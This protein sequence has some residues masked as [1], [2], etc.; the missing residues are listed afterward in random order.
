MT[1][2]PEFTASPI[3]FAILGAGR[4]GLEHGR[5]LVGL[6]EAQVV[7]VADPIEEAAQRVARL[8]RAGRTYS[9]PLDA[10]HDPEVQAVIIVTPT[11]THA[12]LIEAAANAGKAIFCEKPVAADLA[13]TERVMRIVEERG[14]PFQ[15]GFQRRF[16]AGFAQARQR[17]LAGELGTVE[18]FSATGRDPAPPSLDYLKGSGGIFLDQAI[19]D[20]DIARFLVGEV[21]EVTAIGD[22]K[23]D[24]AIGEIGDA[25]TT[26]ALLKFVGGAQ[27]VVQN[28]RRAVYGYDVR[29]EVFGSGGKL[30]LEATPKTP[31]LRYGEGVSMDHYHFFM[32]RF[33]DAYRAEIAAFVAFLRAGEVP[34]PGPRDAV[35][36]LRL[37]LACTRSL[38]EGRPVRVAEVQAGEAVPS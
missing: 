13:E 15:I 28:S 35:E 19:H 27:G 9:D 34:Q 2:S 20:L 22:A 31:L 32:D 38:Q 16:D 30:V 5:A 36:S 1:Q 4:M 7:A 3:R 10:I 14:V 18:Q 25:D 6:P 11:R 29:T 26:T 23:V 8:T 21:E 33:Q 12:A 17:I 24:P 37:A